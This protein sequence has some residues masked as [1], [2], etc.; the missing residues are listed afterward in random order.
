MSSAAANFHLQSGSPAID[1]A[2]TAVS[3][4]PVVDFDGA[5]RYD[6]PATANSGSGPV[7]YADRGAFEYRP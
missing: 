5:T 3:A 2:N 6:D 1:A 4:Q 7:A